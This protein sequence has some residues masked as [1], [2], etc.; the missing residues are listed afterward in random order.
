MNPRSAVGPSV[1][2]ALA[3]VAATAA[4]WWWQ[5]SVFRT[6][7]VDVREEMW[8]RVKDE[9]PI[10][11]DNQPTA[12]FSLENAAAVAR[13]NPF[14][15][16]R[17]VVPRSVPEGK[18]GGGGEA[19]EF[20]T[21]RFIYRGHIRVGQSQRAILEDAATK[22]THFLEVGQEVAGFKV[23]DIAQQ[24]VVLWNVKTQE[25]VVVSLVSATSPEGEETGPQ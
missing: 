9:Y 21:P 19:G 16:T 6:P 22:K 3:L 14:S 11:N 4:V 2:L 24:Q 23:L 7:Q 5:I 25:R 17:H 13:A 20:L 8:K 15:P 12:S 18:E 10:V 1:A